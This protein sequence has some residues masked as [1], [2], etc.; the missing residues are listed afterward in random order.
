MIA[1]TC[2]GAGLA[3]Y[4]VIDFTNF[5]AQT[6]ALALL[7]A[8]QNST[9]NFLKYLP[10]NR[11]NDIAVRSQCSLGGICYEKLLEKGNNKISRWDFVLLAHQPEADLALLTT[12]LLASLVLDFVSLLLLGTA[13]TFNVLE[14]RGKLRK[15][16]TRPYMKCCGKKKRVDVFLIIDMILAF[17]SYFN[18]FIILVIFISIII[19]V[20]IF[21]TFV[22]IFQSSIALFIACVGLAFS[23][24][25][26][27]IPYA[28]AQKATPYTRTSYDPSTGRTLTR[29]FFTFAEKSDD[30]VKSTLSNFD[31]T[32]TNITFRRFAREIRGLEEYQ[33][34]VSYIRALNSPLLST[35]QQLACKQAYTSTWKPPATCGQTNVRQK[36]FVLFCFVFLLF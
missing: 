22:I 19:I 34:H 26:T 1:L 23:N 32:N 35:E 27:T 28:S 17:V 25:I 31:L 15:K 9:S 4:A 11:F 21:L 2:G 10:P 36:D 6:S 8:S 18:F 12:L 29:T 24:P 20:V 33:L 13:I 14:Q 7:A 5:T 30:I 16:L 3:V